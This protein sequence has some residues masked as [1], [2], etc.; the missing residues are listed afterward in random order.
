MQSRKKIRSRLNCASFK[1]NR[2]RPTISSLFSYRSS[3]PPPP[4]L[5]SLLLL[6]FSLSLSLSVF[7]PTFSLLHGL[8]T[9]TF[10]SRLGSGKEIYHHFS[11]LLNPFLLYH[12]ILFCSTKR[13]GNL[14]C[15][16]SFPTIRQSVRHKILSN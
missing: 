3:F 10:G 15:C 16:S 7:M 9:C 2:Q 4:H 14:S 12:L 5:F 13:R 11:L 6:F 8:K 1:T